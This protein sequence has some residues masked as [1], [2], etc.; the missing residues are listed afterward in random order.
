MNAT[1]RLKLQNELASILQECATAS[2]FS[3]ECALSLICRHA[4]KA[5]AIV[6][7]PEPGSES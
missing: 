2:D 3:A 5:L 7:E 6:N 1:K 4:E